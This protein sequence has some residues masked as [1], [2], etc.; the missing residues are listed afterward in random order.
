MCDV[1]VYVCVYVCVCGMC[2]CGGGV[3]TCFWGMWVGGC[4]VSW[5]GCARGLVHGCV[6]YVCVCYSVCQFICQCVCVLCLYVYKFVDVCSVCVGG[7]GD[8]EG[9]CCRGS[10]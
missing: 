8:V 3:D 4:R 7:G 2:V 6:F 5:V 9:W 1:C 10:V